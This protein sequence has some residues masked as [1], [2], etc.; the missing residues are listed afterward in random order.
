VVVAVEDPK[1]KLPPKRLF[2]AAGWLVAVVPPKSDPCGVVVDA[3]NREEPKPVAGWDW[4]GVVVPAA[5]LFPKSEPPVVVA[6]KML[7]PA[8]VAPWLGFAPS[9][10]L[11]VAAAGVP[12]P[13]KSDMVAAGLLLFWGNSWWFCL[14]REKQCAQDDAFAGG[15]LATGALLGLVW[16]CFLRVDPAAAVCT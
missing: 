13:M 14:P 5:V 11:E 4:V 1:P 8:P 16:F 9:I 6:P 3:P 7:L 2:P 15:R 12:R 10:P